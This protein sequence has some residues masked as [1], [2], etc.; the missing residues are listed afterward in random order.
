[1]M[2]AL[3]QVITAVDVT[4]RS[5]AIAAV[6]VLPENL[7]KVSLDC[8]LAAHHGDKECLHGLHTGLARLAD[9]RVLCD[10]D[11][12][13]KQLVSFMSE[14][15]LPDLHLPLGCCLDSQANTSCPSVDQA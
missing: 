9:L 10:A 7:L 14:L 4:L 1:M 12:L 2:V 8:L 3:Q 5:S 6:S 13:A 15:A 11:F